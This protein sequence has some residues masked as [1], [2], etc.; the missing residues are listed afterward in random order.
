MAIL[1]V[2][3]DADAR[4][5]LERGLRESGDGWEVRSASA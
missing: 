3:D 1:V 4:T 5:A 2:D